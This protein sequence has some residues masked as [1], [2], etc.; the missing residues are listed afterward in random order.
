LNTIFRIFFFILVSKRQV[1]VNVC[2]W[3]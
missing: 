3:Q 2:V 1:Y